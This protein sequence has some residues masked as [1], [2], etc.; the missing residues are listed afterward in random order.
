MPRHWII[1]PFE[2]DPPSLFDKVWQFDLANNVISIGWAKLGDVS[3]MSRQALAEAVA[4]AYPE[5]PPGT[6]GLFTNM[7]WAFYHEIG[8]NDVVIARRG[9]KILAAI[10]KVTRSAVYSPAKN[11]HVRHPNFLGVSWQESPRDLVLPNIV[12]PMHTL[13]EITEEKFNL[14]IKGESSIEV[15]N[16]QEVED[17][18]AFVLE[19]YLEDF[20]VSNFHAFFKKKIEYLQRY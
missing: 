17:Q 20:I 16:P 5:K 3:K 12:F 18:N 8:P 10:G 2:V 9:R 14:L 4:S 19:K 7:I 6:K 13:Y 1:A 15:L 11:P